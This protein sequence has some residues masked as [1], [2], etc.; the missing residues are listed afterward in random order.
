MPNKRTNHRPP[1]KRQRCE[2]QNAPTNEPTKTKS[3]RNK[4]QPSTKRR[5]CEGQNAQAD[6]PT[7]NH[8]P[9]GG[10]ANRKKPPKK[11]NNRQPRTKRRRGAGQNAPTLTS[12]HPKAPLKSSPWEL[13]QHK[14]TL[15]K[16]KS[17]CA[18]RAIRQGLGQEPAIHD[19]G[20]LLPLR[21]STVALLW[22]SKCQEIQ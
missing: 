11:R 14:R 17:P 2:V 3:K 7:T 8:Q 22:A 12:Q 18:M 21:P 13:K 5:R 9:K 1:T 6:E 4:H 20:H 15:R 16:G 10:A 19:N